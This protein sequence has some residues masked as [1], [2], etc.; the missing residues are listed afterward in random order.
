MITIK[1]WIAVGM[2]R[3]E[4]TIKDYILQFQQVTSS[5]ELAFATEPILTNSLMNQ[6]II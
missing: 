3:I 6:H 5:P 4:K 2:Q 1:N